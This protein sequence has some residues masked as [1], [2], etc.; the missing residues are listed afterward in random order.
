MIYNYCCY[1]VLYSLSQIDKINVFIKPSYTR[2]NYYFSFITFCCA[3]T[4][5]RAKKEEDKIESKKDKFVYTVPYSV[6]GTFYRR[7]T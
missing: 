4:R 2:V 6:H 7:Q 1:I 3:L 5:R